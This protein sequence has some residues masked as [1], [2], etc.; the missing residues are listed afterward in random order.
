MLR[1]LKV[2]DCLKK[3]KTTNHD[4]H[5]CMNVTKFSEEK[6]SKCVIQSDQCFSTFSKP[7][8]YFFFDNNQK[9]TKY[10]KSETP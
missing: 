2:K 5:V 8:S 4:N 6:L 1:P 3:S 10:K 7:R 9:K